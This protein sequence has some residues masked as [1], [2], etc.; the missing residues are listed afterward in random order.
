MIILLNFESG[1]NVLNT[2]FRSSWCLITD[3]NFVHR[4]LHNVIVGGDGDIS[5]I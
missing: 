5:E 4:L 2:D 3:V 1:L